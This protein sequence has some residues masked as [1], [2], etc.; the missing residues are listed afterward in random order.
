MIEREVLAEQV[1]M[2]QQCLAGIEEE[3]ALILE[4]L[5]ERV[6]DDFRLV[7]GA[8]AGEELAAPPPECRGARRCS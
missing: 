6:I 3:D 7:L 8:N 2:L 4:L 5:L 1:L